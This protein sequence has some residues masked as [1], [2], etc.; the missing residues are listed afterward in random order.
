MISAGRGAVTGCSPPRATTVPSVS[1]MTDG[2]PA[3]GAPA[4]RQAERNRSRR[5]R[6]DQPPLRRVAVALVCSTGGGKVLRDQVARRVEL[7]RGLE[8]TSCAT[9]GSARLARP[10]SVP[11]GG[12]SM[13]AVTPR[14]VMV[15][16]AQV[17]AH[18]RGDLGDDPLQ[19]FLA[20][21]DRRAVGVGQQRDRRILGRDAGGRLAQGRDGR[22][23]VPGVEGP[24]H[25]QRA[26]PG[27]GR[28]IGR[29]GRQVRQRPGGHDLSR[30]VDVRGGEAVP[31]NGLEHRILVAAEHSG[32]PGRLGRRCRR[33]CRRRAPRP[34]ASR[35]PRP[36]RRR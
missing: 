31:G 10:V 19:P 1:G 33:H 29:E 32:H 27:A 16:H 36:A 28:R 13:S 23:H 17:P 6:D 18:R 30:G 3:R 21:G 20:G 8:A 15:A 25:L 5:R 34:G 9:P 22:R 2:G 7:I 35:R 4:C 11:A 24:G 26:Q 12:S 14:S